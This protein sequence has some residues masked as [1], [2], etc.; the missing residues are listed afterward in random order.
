LTLL[1]DRGL[2]VPAV[3]TREIAPSVFWIACCFASANGDIHGHLSLYLVVGDQKT[4]LVDMG[5][6]IH[7]P[8]IEQALE[9]LLGDRTL[10]YAVPTHPEPAHSGNL[11]KIVTRYPEARIVG[12]VRDYHLIFPT[13]ADRLLPMAA[14][15]RILLG[16]GAELVLLPAV[17]RDLPNTQWIYEPRSQVMFVADGFLYRHMPPGP[18]GDDAPHRPDECGLLSTELPSLPDAANTGRIFQNALAWARFVD[19]SPIFT[20]LEALFARYQPAFLAPAHGNVIADIASILPVMREAF[21]HAREVWR[22]SSGGP[23]DSAR[24]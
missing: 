19:G 24:P 18:D 15:S 14:G 9:R 10:D 6:S 8:A 12:D 5:I 1:D 17:L 11:A 7:Y 21:G 3:K 20:D 23:H 22:V 16:G 13:L 2:P 4:A